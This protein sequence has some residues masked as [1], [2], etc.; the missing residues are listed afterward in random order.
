MVSSRHLREFLGPGE[1]Q[2]D[3]MIHHFPPFSAETGAT[4]GTVL[5]QESVLES[6]K[7]RAAKG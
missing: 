3:F 5:G 4:F 1:A 7:G 2:T 6:E